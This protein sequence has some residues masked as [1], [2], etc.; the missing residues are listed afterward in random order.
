[1]GEGFQWGKNYKIKK[2]VLSVGHY[3]YIGPDSHIIYPT[4]VGDLC[5]IAAGVQF[6]GNDHGYNDIDKPIRISSP[7]IDPRSITTVVGPDVW[8]GQSAIILHGVRIGRGAIIA[9]GSVVTKDVSPYSIVAGV[10]A[11]KIKSRFSTRQQIEG[12]EKLL[13]GE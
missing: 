5:L 9:A 6:V 13:Y 2:G 7:K 4:I 11:C 8:I 1:L 12:Y 3:A 10:P